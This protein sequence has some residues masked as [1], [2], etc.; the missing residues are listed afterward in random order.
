MVDKKEDLPNA[1][2]LNSFLFNGARLVGPYR[3]RHFDCRAE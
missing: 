3:R 2:A 1:I